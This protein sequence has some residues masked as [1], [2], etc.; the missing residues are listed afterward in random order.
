M[1]IGYFSWPKPSDIPERPRF[2]SYQLNQES[3]RTPFYAL[4]IE[5][6]L[7]IH[8]ELPFRSC[9]SLW[10]TCKSL[11]SLLTNSDFMGRL[12]RDA[13]V[14]GHLRWILPVETMPQ[15]HIFSDILPGWELLSKDVPTEPD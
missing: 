14:S 3:S 5:L 15:E 8:H 13:I 11:R 4:S 1:L 9:L 6:L 7:Q 10:S 2:A 12:L